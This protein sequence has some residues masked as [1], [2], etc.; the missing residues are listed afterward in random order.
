[1]EVLEVCKDNLSSELIFSSDKKFKLDK[2]VPA[3]IFFRFVETFSTSFFSNKYSR[4]ESFIIVQVFVKSFLVTRK[5]E[6]LVEKFCVKSVKSL[7][8]F[9]TSSQTFTKTPKKYFCEKCSTTTSQSL[10]KYF[11]YP[12]K[13]FTNFS[14]FRK[15]KNYSES[16]IIF[17]RQLQ[18]L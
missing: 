1:M 14:N 8:V 13:F 5:F 4:G 16:P 15:L 2:N 7:E 9:V 18:N 3:L 12:N 6:M 11:S 17:S 10:K